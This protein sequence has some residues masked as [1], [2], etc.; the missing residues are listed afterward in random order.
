M[1]NNS[2]V[3][4]TVL[5]TDIMFSMYGSSNIKTLCEQSVQQFSQVHC[6][7]QTDILKL[8]YFSISL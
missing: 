2:H 1:I 6:R 5:L 7:Q 4:I 8:D 3:I